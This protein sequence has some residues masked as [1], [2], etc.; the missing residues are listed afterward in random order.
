MNGLDV[1]R[2]RLLRLQHHQLPLLPSHYVSALASAASD[3]AAAPVP[4]AAPAS[5]S[6]IAPVRSCAVC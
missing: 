6:A 2:H 5:A 3:H 4:A 1:A